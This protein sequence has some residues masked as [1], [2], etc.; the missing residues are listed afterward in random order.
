MHTEEGA[1]RKVLIIAKTY[2]ELSSKYG[3]TVCTAAIDENG[4]AL[5][6]YPIPFRYLSGPQRFHRYQWI[7]GKMKKSERDGRPESYTIEPE[8]ISLGNQVPPTADEWGRRREFIFKSTRW[9]FDSMRALLKSEKTTGQSLAF[10]RPA[11]IKSVS[12]KPREPNDAITFEGKLKLLREQNTIARK[13]LDLF[14]STVPASMKHLEYVSGRIC[15]D[16]YCSDPDCAGHSMQILDWEICELSRREGLD[17]AKNKVI[18]L[19]DL[20]RYNTGF[21]LGNIHMYPASFAIIGLWY[22]TRSNMLF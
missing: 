7:T 15:V 14:E 11:R 20:E 17:A 8:S 18:E 16:W 5:R 9:Q 3:E 4:E 21:F 6:L 19:L 12:I 22:P 10:L 2:P 13:Q 1:F